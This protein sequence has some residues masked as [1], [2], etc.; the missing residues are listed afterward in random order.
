MLSVSKIFLAELIWGLTLAGFK[1][2]W[3]TYKSTMHRNP[4]R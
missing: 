4:E 2:E 3:G 1:A